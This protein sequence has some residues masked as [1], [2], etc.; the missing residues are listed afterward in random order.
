ML[1]TVL[2]LTVS[3]SAASR[4][5]DLR[6]AVSTAEPLAVAAEDI[7]RDLSDADAASAETFLSAAQAGT[8]GEDRYAADLNRVSA[9][10]AAVDADTRGSDALR[11]ADGVL[12]TGLPVFTK[13]IGAALADAR[14]NLPVGAA[15]LREASALLRD[16]LLPAA[17]Q[18][19]KVESDRL[20]A[21]DDDA[22]AAYDVEL[23][24]VAATLAALIATQYFVRRR[25]SRTL[26]PGLLAA[27]SLVLV[28]AIWTLLAGSAERDAVSAAKAHWE[29]AD[30]AIATDLAAVRAHG[31]E[32]LGLAARGEDVGGYEHDFATSTA[33]LDA[34]VKQNHG[35]YADD[36][37]Q[38][39]QSWAQAHAA[40]LPAENDPQPDNAANV[41]ALQLLTQPAAG[42]SDAG[43]LRVD[44]DLRQGAGAEEAGYLAKVRAG[45]GDLEGLDVATAVLMTAAVALAGYGL[46]RRL[47]EYR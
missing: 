39:R 6:H 47:R 36:V 43:F 20:K 34:L 46:D 35:A 40:L 31:D 10:L 18:A 4:Q 9:N 45:H 22:G 7:Y 30:A 3:L 24:V 2:G 42:G 8:S 25:T 27:T 32:L 33:R 29:A 16:R 14:Q 11:A 1:I 26:N 19:L 12:L 5:N 17:Q 41:K 13:L 37:R 23:G 44:Q 21:D 28:V 38:A 15:Y